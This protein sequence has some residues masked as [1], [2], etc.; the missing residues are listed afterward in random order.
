MPSLE[1][2]RGLGL[3]EVEYESVL[4]SVSDTVMNKKERIAQGKYTKYSNE[5]HAKIGRY[6]LENGNE[7]A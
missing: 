2:A 5:D 3:G 7:Q 4:N 6:A 1:E